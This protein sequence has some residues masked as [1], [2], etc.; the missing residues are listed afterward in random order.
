MTYEKIKRF[1][2]DEFK[3]TNLPAFPLDISQHVIEDEDEIDALANATPDKQ[4]DPP[5]PQPPK[6]QPPKPAT[7]KKEEKKEEKKDGGKGLFGKKK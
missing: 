7:E 3:S 6:K 5:K 2:R 4:V 1:L